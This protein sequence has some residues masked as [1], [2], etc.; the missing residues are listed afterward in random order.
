MEKLSLKNCINTMGRAW[1]NCRIC[2]KKKNSSIDY[3]EYEI[4]LGEYL[5]LLGKSLLILLAISYTFYHS[6]LLFLFFIPFALLIP[7]FLRAELRKKRQNQLL[8][9]FKEMISILS[10]FLSAGYSIENAFIATI[11]DLSALIGEKS[12]MVDEL[13]QIKRALSINR[14]LEE[15]LS[16]FALR[17]GLDDIHNFSEIFLV[18]KRSGGE[19]CEIIQHSSSIIHD[20]LTIREE[21]LTLSAAKRFEQ[22]IMNAIPFFIILYL[23]VSSP[24]FFSILYSSIMGRIIMTFALLIY[25]FAIYLSQKI[26]SIP[27]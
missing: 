5:W 23:N 19:L 16:Q 3:R 6:F 1:K 17:S 27:I 22:K 20:K 15:P 25:L 14:P 9:Q 4:S 21:I 8:I 26:I 10:S 11:P 13:K 2:L 12:Y 7:F 24:D 18:A